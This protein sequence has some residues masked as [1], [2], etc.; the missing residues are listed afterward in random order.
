MEV[1]KSLEEAEDWEKLEVW[2]EAVWR[3]LTSGMP[4]PKLMEGVKQVTLKLS[5]RQPSALQR[6][7]NLC[8]GRA[9]W[10]ECRDKLQGV[11]NQALAEQLPSEPPLS[12]YVSVPPT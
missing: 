8:G 4:T 12:P 10:K 7:K 6:F 2:L 11:C 5:L 9:L 1:M 3:S